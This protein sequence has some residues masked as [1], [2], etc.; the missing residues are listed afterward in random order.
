MHVG[1]PEVI[2]RQDEQG[3]TVEPIEDVYIEVAQAMLGVVM[4]MLGARRGE[5]R[6]LRT[7]DDGTVHLHF[8]VPTRGL[9]GFRSKF[10]TSTRGTGV[11]NTLFHGYAPLAGEI[12]TREHGS[13]VAWEDGVATT[14]GLRNAEE[15]GILFIEPGAPVYEGMVVGEHARSSDLVVNVAKKKHLTNV[16][17]A[18]AEMLEGLTPPRKMSLDECIEYLGDDEL[19]EVTPQSL[20]IRKKILSTL[21]RKRAYKD[22]ARE[23]E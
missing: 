3:E 16:R 14:Y 2:F 5:L 6:D 17:S 9:L 13:L 22:R 20:R 10:L 8:R 15:R 18:G 1:K 12:D 11:L 7:L 21:E 4:E 23:M 19:L